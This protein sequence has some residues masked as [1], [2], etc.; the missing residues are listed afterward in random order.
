L[1]GKR[2]SGVERLEVLEENTNNIQIEKLIAKDSEDAVVSVT[3]TDPTQPEPVIVT[4][5]PK[6]TVIHSIPS[7]SASDH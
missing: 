1:D 3:P 5:K 7:F 4:K 2:P 6:K